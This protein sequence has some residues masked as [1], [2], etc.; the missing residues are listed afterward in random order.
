MSTDMSSLITGVAGKQRG[1]TSQAN[2]RQLKDLESGEAQFKRTLTGAVI[3]TVLVYKDGHEEKT[4][5]MPAKATTYENFISNVVGYIAAVCP[6]ALEDPE[7]VK[8]LE[9]TPNTDGNPA[10]RTA[11]SYGSKGLYEGQTFSGKGDRG[12]AVAFLKKIGKGDLV[13]Q[14]PH[15][16]KK[17]CPL[18]AVVNKA[19]ELNGKV[20]T[21]V[22]LGQGLM[23]Q[24]KNL[25]SPVDKAALYNGVG[26]KIKSIMDGFNK[27][28]SDKVRN[29]LIQ[30]A[31]ANPLYKDLILEAAGKIP[32]GPDHDWTLD[33]V[34][35]IPELTQL[36]GMFEMMDETF[37][38]AWTESESNEV[39]NTVEESE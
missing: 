31:E 6:E 16:L 24:A 10:L 9:E 33:E 28:E 34:K 30:L 15:S 36:M 11:L 12:V 14:V 29:G 37:S 26:F 5:G 25:K 32:T 1:L 17:D 3:K 21:V 22:T 4:V 18:K 23:T 27:E 7:F 35:A 8:N 2:E 13:E 39:D 38:E 19:A 20:Q